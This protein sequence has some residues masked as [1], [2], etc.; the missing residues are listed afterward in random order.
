MT[1]EVAAVERRAWVLILGLFLVV[2]VSAFEMTAVLTA[3]PTITAD[4]HGEAY[5]GATF[6]AYLLATLISVVAAGELADRRGPGVPLAIGVMFFMGGLLV[7]GT[8]HSALVV[9]LGRVLQGLGGGAQA[10]LTYVIIRRAVPERIHPKVYAIMSAGWVIPSLFAPF[11]AGWITDRFGWRWVFLSL[12]PLIAIVGGFVFAKARSL[13]AL[14]TLPRR[15]R[16]ARGKYQW[17]PVAGGRVCCRWAAGL[18]CDHPSPD[19]DRHVPLDTWPARRHCGP[20]ARDRC[21]WRSR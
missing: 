8:A 4:L 14:T 6:A 20:T 2:S 5:Y 11:V 7:A 19:A 12:I 13:G 3:L 10:T 21:V 17:E 16:S 1:E 18:C 9:V 15:G